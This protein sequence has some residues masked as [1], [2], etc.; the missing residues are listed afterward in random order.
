MNV[1][2]QHTRPSAGG[3]TDRRLVNPFTTWSHKQVL[4]CADDFVLKSGLAEYSDLFRKGASL[5]QS[6]KLFENEEYGGMSLL[7]KERNALK[8][9]FSN[10]RMDRFKQPLKL[11]GLVACCSLGAAVQGW[12]QTAVNGAQIYFKKT[13][14]ME[15]NANLLGLVN[16]AP[17]L[18]CALACCLNYPLNKY[19]DRRGVI[20]TTCIISSVTCLLQAFSRTWW[21]LFLARFALGFGIGPKSATI[22][23]YAAEAAPENI[24]GALVMMWQMWTAFGIMCGYFSGVAFA[25]VAGD[26]KWRLM[27]GSPMVLPLL[28]VLYIYALPESPRVLLDKARKRKDDASDLYEKAFLGLRSLRN[29][30]VQAA[31]DLFLMDYLLE[32]ESKIMHDHKRFQELFTQR[33]C[34]NALTAS[35]ICMF[36]QQMCGVNVTVYYSSSIMT[37][38]ANWSPENALL[39]SAGFGIINFVFAFPAAWTIDT[40]GR[41]NL[42][43]FTFPF[44]ALFQFVMVVAVALP[45]NTSRR[46]LAIV[47]MYLFGIAYSPGEGPVPFVYS[48]E[49]MPL[50]N[51]DYGM[52]IVTAI[53]W[54]F[55]FI[56]SFTWPSMS[57][58]DG[59]GPSGAF[60]W[61]GV[62]CLIGWW[63]ILLFVPE[64]K[65]LTLEEL[66]IVFDKP[67]H[68]YMRH[69]IA[70]LKWF[71]GYHVLRK[72]RM[73][74][75]RPVFLNPVS[76]T[77][78]H[79]PRG[80]F[81][82]SS[83]EL[84][85]FRETSR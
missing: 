61:Y 75:E 46:A 64:T 55:N 51:R 10:N 37:E 14:G 36:L 53:N 34:R 30:K 20:F 76:S 49:S 16:G 26:L 67:P 80:D 79:D 9:E 15:N 66:D 19:L 6:N 44:M 81:P 12:D 82:D 38:N 54:L 17:Y 42:L 73:E 62:W 56:V 69:G 24:R 11:Y 25:K 32:E 21:H 5:A 2:S 18:C 8:L 33:R 28:V 23:I 27:L 35:V 52:G 65:D 48:A 83:H 43:L 7:L 59:L 50:Y 1:H 72:R 3:K 84:S 22:P 71:I 58:E 60:A 57:G 39:L 45:D 70:Q 47:G 74:K 77:R 13:L 40:F 29:S 41:R 78:Q 4:D 85:G 68:D 31:R 63:L